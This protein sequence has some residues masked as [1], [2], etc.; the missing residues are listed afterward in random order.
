MCTAFVLLA[1]LSGR[2]YKHSHI[3]VISVVGSFLFFENAHPLV[4]VGWT[5]NYEMWFYLMFC[6]SLA[7]FASARSAVPFIAILLLAPVLAGR[8]MGHNSTNFFANPIMIEFLFGMAVAMIFVATPPSPTL[9]VFAAVI[10]SGGMYLSSALSR[11][12]LTAGLDEQI[13]WLAWGVPAAFAVYAA[14]FVAKP[15]TRLGRALLLLGD[16]SYAIYLTHSIVMTT[17]A[18]ILKSGALAKV[19]MWELIPA[20][21]ALA[22]GIGTAVHLRIER[23]ILDAL[24]KAQLSRQCHAKTGS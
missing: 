11:S 7:L 1:T 23:P 17:Y 19:P 12:T 4:S 6:I 13:R 2:L 16:S 20:V 3:S 14:L 18:A 5:L 22:L 9:P 10:A 8:L 15:S 24:H 21:V